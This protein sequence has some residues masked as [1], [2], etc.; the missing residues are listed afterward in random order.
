MEVDWDTTPSPLHTLVGRQVILS[1]MDG[2]TRGGIVYTVDR[3]SKNF[4]LVQVLTTSFLHPS[5]HFFYFF[6]LS[7]SLSCF[8]FHF[9]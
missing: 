1:I 8:S 9:R 3:E 7:L 6:S 4:F 2:S 5:L